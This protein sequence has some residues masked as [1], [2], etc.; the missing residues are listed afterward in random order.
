MAAWASGAL[1]S[2]SW[3]SGAWEGE[4]GPVGSNVL[5]Y[6][7]SRAIGSAETVTLDY[8]QPGNGV[9]DAVSND[10]ESFSGF[11]VVNNSTQ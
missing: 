4:G 3:A 7:I 1:A 10:A 9:E 11:S 2:G 8:V 5:V 6:T